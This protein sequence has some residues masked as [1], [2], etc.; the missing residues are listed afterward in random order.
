M[1]L[2][3][4][5][6]VWAPEGD[7]GAAPAADAP[8]ADAVVATDPAD[9]SATL[10]PDDQPAPPAGDKPEVDPAA[11]QAAD[12]AK[13]DAKPDGTKTDGEWAEYVDDPAKT[14][15]END[16]ARLENDAKHPVNQVP[17][18]GNYALTMPDGVEL[19]SEMMAVIGP[20]FKDLNLSNGH[21]QMIADKFIE[22]QQQRAGKQAEGWAQ[23]ITKWADDAKA[24][25]EMGGN[26]WDGTVTAA[27]S[28][29]DRFGTP[30]LKEYLEA[31]GAG[32]HPEIIRLMA[33]VGAMIGEDDPAI[34][35]NPGVKPSADRAV[36]MYPNDQP[37]KGK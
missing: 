3:R 31:S 9:P 34:S 37:K 32:N 21:A 35:E 2:M 11:D 26:K 18:D 36:A 23:T 33:K 19:D 6:P 1:F 5:K 25:P 15:E 7:S 27:K 4:N 20:V 13:D 12:P 24:D 29:V 28:T 16:A 14:K 30:A 8:A 17:E 10:Y 22:V